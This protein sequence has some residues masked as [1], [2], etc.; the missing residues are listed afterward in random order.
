MSLFER[1]IVDFEYTD[2]RGKLVQLVHEGF[3]QVNI[4][5]TKKGVTRGGHYHKLCCEAFFVLQGKVDVTLQKMGIIERVTFCEN[6]FF[7]IEPNVIHSMYFPQN[8]LMLQMYD[9]P[10]ENNDGIKDIYP[11]H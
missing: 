7:R 11:E 6:D 9:I 3:S 10:V 2:E 4:L 1:L 5:E 8:C